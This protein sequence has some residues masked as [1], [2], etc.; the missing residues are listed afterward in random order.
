MNTS[1]DQVTGMLERVVYGVALALAMKFVS[2]G[3]L[4]ADM[5]PYVAGYFVGERALRRRGTTSSTGVIALAVREMMF[6][7]L[8][9]SAGRVSVPYCAAC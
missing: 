9:I 1:K 6:F 8:R 4:D 3:L 7:E 2:W 5:A